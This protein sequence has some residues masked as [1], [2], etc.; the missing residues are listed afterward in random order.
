MNEHL[1]RALEALEAGAAEARERS[2]HS[3]TH[4]RSSLRRTTEEVL[5]HLEADARTPDAEADDLMS[6][7]GQQSRDI[8]EDLRRVERL[9]RQRTGH[10]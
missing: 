9:M 1:R 5:R 2:L 10:E 3:A 8:A 6:R 4:V 7:L